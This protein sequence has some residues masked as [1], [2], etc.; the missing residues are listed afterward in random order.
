V[1]GPAGRWVR[2]ADRMFATLLQ[3]PFVSQRMAFADAIRRDQSKQ[4]LATL[5]GLIEAGK[6]TPV[7]DRRYPFAD[8][9]AAV[10]YQEQG[11]VPGKVVV[12]F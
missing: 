10:A 5:T 8:L 3:N 7:I 6:V 1:G 4:H 12:T 11:H 2:P 9:P